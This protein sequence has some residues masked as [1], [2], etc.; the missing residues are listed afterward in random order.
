M[1]VSEHI[2]SLLKKIPNRPGVYR[3]YDA[4]GTIIYVGK[5]KKLK[6]RVSSYFNK[7]KYENRKTKALVKQIRDIKFLEV[8]SEQD[9]FLLENTLIKK[10]FPK[11]NIQLKDNKTFP[12]ICIRKEPFPRV[13]STRNTSRSK[14]EYFG[15]YASVKMMHSLLDLIRKM[16]KIRTCSLSL[17]EKNIQADKF[18][19]CLEYHL[20]NCKGP[21]VGNQEAQ[22]YDRVIHEV[23]QIL[24]G[25]LKAVF[26]SLNKEMAAYVER[27]EFEEA[28]VVKEKI[29]R[30]QKY[31]GKSTVVSSQNINAEVYGLV[32]D[33]KRSYVH[34]MN[35][36]DGAV[37]NGYSVEINTK[38]DESP[39][40]IMAFA[41]ANIRSKLTEPQSAILSSTEVLST[42][43]NAEVIVPQRGDKKLLIELAERNAKYFMFD[44][45]KQEKIVDPDRHYKRVLEQT[46]NDLRLKE[47][48]HHIECFDN[49][50]FQGTNAVAA[51]VVFRNAKPAKKDYRHFNIKTVV[52][53]DDYAS[54][55]EV[56]L[57]RYKRMV[58]ED[59][60][61]PQLIVIDGGKGQLSA[62]VKSLEKLNLRGKI[63]I[64]G[65]AKRLEEIYFPDDPIPLYIDKRS[66][67]L[68]LIQNLRNEA[69]RFGITHHRNKRSKAALSTELTDIK[70]IGRGSADL[71][72]TEFGSVKNV[73]EATE[74]QLAKYIGP[75]KASF[76]FHYFRSK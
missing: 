10:H 31:Q 66:E 11:Y 60:P 55:E 56:I 30:L 52:G 3:F 74:E 26:K 8:D 20:K 72:L 25:N 71:L 45:K 68:K 6:N 62:A 15:P 23:R 19:V 27:L 50:N 14:D 38:L 67:S 32:Q 7:I 28:Q 58:E 46:K 43:D 35:V 2:R 42:F 22:D 17:T 64:I 49:S 57:R 51:C 39:S 29:A 63:S 4:E 5:A 9:A 47:L 1:Q 69:H 37:V 21:C 34:Y 61:L 24:R 76:V 73:K 12:W 54:M 13:F 48:P 41:I 75:S 33:F 59:Q 18:K 40:E 65:I 70:G 53:P 16:Y 44:K 36:I